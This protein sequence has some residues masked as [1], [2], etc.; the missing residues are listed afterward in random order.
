MDPM[1]KEPGGLWVKVT[2]W[3]DPVQPN[4]PNPGHPSLGLTKRTDLEDP[5]KSHVGQ[6]R[7]I[8]LFPKIVVPPNLLFLIEFS[9]INHPFWGTTFFGN[10]HI[11]THIIRMYV[12]IF[13]RH[14]SFYQVYCIPSIIGKY[15]CHHKETYGWHF[16]LGFGLVIVGDF[17]DGHCNFDGMNIT[18]FCTTLGHF[19]LP[20]ASKS[21]V[22]FVTKSSELPQAIYRKSGVP[23]LP[24]CFFFRKKNIFFFRRT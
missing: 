13:N 23:R 7:K 1:G 15:I 19:S 6:S 11:M 14:L 16:K 18:I 5:R 2:H 4:N 24:G 20:S 8:Q 3:S 12:I 22:A 9:I 10:I 21:R 17:C